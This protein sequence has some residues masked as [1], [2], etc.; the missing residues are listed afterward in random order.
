M[1]SVLKTGR[2]RRGKQKG[3]GLMTICHGPSLGK[4]RHLQKL[5]KQRR[6]ILPFVFG[7]VLF[8]FSVLSVLLPGA[9][10]A[11]EPDAPEKIISREEAISI[12]LAN[13]LK[14]WRQLSMPYQQTKRRRAELKGMKNY[15]AAHGYKPIWVDEAG[16]NDK[17]R[18]VIAEMEASAKYGLNPRDYRWPDP[19]RVAAELEREGARPADILAKAEIRMSLAALMYASHA[20]GGRINPSLYTKNIDRV[21]PYVKPETALEK[22]AAT[23]D[24]AAYLAG[25]HPTHPQ[26]KLL[27]AELARLEG[28]GNGEDSGIAERAPKRPVIIPPGRVLRIGISHPH[29]RLLRERLNVPAGQGAGGPEDVYDEELAEAVRAFQREN[30]LYPDG[31]VG[32]KTRLALNR[33][34]YAPVTPRNEKQ[35]ILINL[36]RWRWMPRDLGWKYVR[37]NL[38][39]FKV[40]VYRNGERIFEERI[41]IGKRTHKTPVFSDEMEYV[42]FNPYW[43]V[44]Q[45]IIWTEMG[46]RIPYGFEGEWRNGRLSVRQPPGPKNAL[47][48]IKFRFPNKHAVYLHDTPQK[49]LFNKKVRMFSHGC[50]RVRNPERLAYAVFDDE[51]GWSRRKVDQYYKRWT[52]KEVRLPEKIPVHVV[53]FTAWAKDDGTIQYFDD[54]YGHD[55]RI[56]IALKYRRGDAYAPDPVEARAKAALRA[57]ARYNRQWSSGGWSDNGWGGGYS[58]PV[59]TL[60]GNIFGW[61]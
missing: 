25:L 26:Y 30:G 10:Q 38:P 43:Y 22:M 44:P 28:R 53:Y 50:M 39:E 23:D 27:M 16:L 4:V 47:G 29:V 3:G 40:F 58:S 57:R 45:S 19:E 13:H 7:A 55:K 56:A 37:V 52:R 2:G 36:E 14:T 61:N 59:E 54:I 20:S 21:G 49:H 8:S 33:G 41:V 51:P 5:D 31:R 1:T 18:G 32:R 24:A 6:L 34:Q 15:Y 17:A 60:F 11:V 46:G 35:T 42:V 9:A 48:K 12:R